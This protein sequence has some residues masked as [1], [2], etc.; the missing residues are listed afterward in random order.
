MPAAYRALL[1]EAYRPKSLR[2]PDLPT[3]P[4]ELELQAMWYNGLFGRDFTS[5][6]G[7]QVRIRQFGIWNRFAGPDFLNA[8]VEID[9]KVHSGPL[10]ID[11]SPSDWVNH[12]H[13]VN[14]AFDET[15]LHV[16]FQNSHQK[17]FT[18]T[19]SHKEVPVVVVPR[20][21][22]EK[23][24]NAP[25]VPSC[26]AHPGRCSTPL[27]SMPEP[28]VLALMESAAR[29]RC[30]SKATTLISIQEAHG[31][32]Q[33]L[34]IALAQTLGYRP[35]K[36]NMSLMAQRLP[37]HFLSKNTGISTALIFGCAGFLHPEIHEKAPEDSRQWLR[38]LWDTWW[39]H[40]AKH[41]FSQQRAIPW[42]LAGNRPVNHPQRR[43]A[44]L[45][46]I[47]KHW[48]T[49]RKLSRQ[50]IALK[51]WLLDL[52]DQF[53]SHH[54]TLTSK[55]SE[56]KLALLGKDRVQDLLANH[57]LPLLVHEGND[58]AW[59]Q[60]LSLPAPAMSEKVEKASIRLFGKRTDTKKFLRKAWQHQALLQI[61]HDFCLQDT[62]DCKDCPFPEQLKHF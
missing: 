7:A 16:V 39:Q 42:V 10:E 14:P 40:R 12:G 25:S 56:K 22:I 38:E 31:H 43:L 6:D 28:R 57:L 59:H 34:W 48:P 18:R 55:R 61:Y 36:L 20:E 32:D 15:V 26:S 24:L 30:E 4:D 5:E 35:N 54:Y 21:L 19:S 9:Q 2:E 23:A 47:S 44:L 33:A 11:T 45:A 58:H 51:E 50:P 60:Y 62:S 52:T 17:H 49:F 53:W 1:A 27:E 41:E 8:A 37:I 13:D 3:L 46:I 29:H